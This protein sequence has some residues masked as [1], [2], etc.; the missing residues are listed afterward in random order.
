MRRAA[1]AV[2]GSPQQ[3]SAFFDHKGYLRNHD[4]LLPRLI[5]DLVRAASEEPT[6]S[7]GYQLVSKERIAAPSRS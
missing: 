3:L 2:R 1:R 5:N 6:R 4:E 7:G